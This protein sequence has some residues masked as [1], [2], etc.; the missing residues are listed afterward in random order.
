LFFKRYSLIFSV[1]NDKEIRINYDPKN[2][3]FKKC[4][5]LKTILKYKPLKLRDILDIFIPYWDFDIFFE[6][7]KTNNNPITRVKN[8]YIPLVVRDASYR[9]NKS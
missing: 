1:Q 2:A 8:M 3:E 7:T 9:S 6:P 4:A 5:L